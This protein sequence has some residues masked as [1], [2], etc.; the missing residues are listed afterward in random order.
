MTPITSVTLHTMS[1][2]SL[3][4]LANSAGSGSSSFGS[5]LAGAVNHL[6]TSQTAANQAMQTALT[7][8]GSVTGAMVAMVGAQSSLDVATAFRNQALQAYQT[9]INMPLG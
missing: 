7:G 1:P 9:I 3:T 2:I 4:P 5:L 6:T 8:G